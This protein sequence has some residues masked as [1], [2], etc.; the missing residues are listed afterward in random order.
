MQIVLGKAFHEATSNMNI[1]ETKMVANYNG[2]E[3][4]IE[5]R[6]FM[7]D[8]IRD[9]VISGS[10]TYKV[11]SSSDNVGCMVKL[12]NS[13]LSLEKKR[14]ILQLK[15]KECE[16]NIESARIDYEKPFA[17]EQELLEK[18]ERQRE[19]QVLLSVEDDKCLEEDNKL[20]ESTENMSKKVKSR[21]I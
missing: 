9:I 2:F 19:L 7:G 3:I 20:S 21:S 17:K 12:K 16:D 10:G 5:K 15:I 14:E 11:E 6:M 4:G 1:D 13:L 8:V 18:V